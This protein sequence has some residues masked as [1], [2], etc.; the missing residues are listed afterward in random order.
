[1]S[2]QTPQANLS[3]SLTP[4]EL[5]ADKAAESVPARRVMADGAVL[6][7]TGLVASVQPTQLRHPWRSS[8]RTGFQA[9]VG[10]ASLV[11]FV[12]TGVYGDDPAVLPVVVAQTV[13]VSGAVSRVMALPEVETFLR[14]FLPFLSA[15][16]RK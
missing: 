14:R 8:I 9:V 6:P 2:E 7:N 3:R 12:V 10:F 16:P 4:D 15:A 13:A 5:T 1:M 11:P